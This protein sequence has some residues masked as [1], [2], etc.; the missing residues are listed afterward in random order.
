MV[1]WLFLAAL[2]LLAWILVRRVSRLLGPAAQP[3]PLPGQ[4][5]HRAPHD[6][7]GV[8][9]GAS[10]DEIRRAYQRLVRQYHP[11]RVA[12][13]APELRALAEQRTK[14][15]NRAFESLS[16]KAGRRPS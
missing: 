5:D 8:S 6:V 2:F 1:R 9:A 4:P 14:E 15:I 13:M 7:L 16:G 11:D 10:E 12:T 3:Q